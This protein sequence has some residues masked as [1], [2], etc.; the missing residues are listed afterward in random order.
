MYR[1]FI[2][3]LSATAITIT[4]FGAVPAR[5]DGDDVRRALGIL[6]GAAIVG[7]I[8]HDSEKRDRSVTRYVEPQHGH[9]IKPQAYPRAK[10][11]TQHRRAGRKLLPSK[12]F[13]SFD[14][15]RGR[16]VMFGQ[17]CLQKNFAHAH[18][19]PQSCARKARTQRGVRYGYDARCLRDAGYRLARG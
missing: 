6:L 5:A 3:V 10:P 19:L 11:Q 7:K 15:R 14:T 2:A 8:I 18:R 1:R 12:C 17:R 16:V 9:R 4:A 13:R